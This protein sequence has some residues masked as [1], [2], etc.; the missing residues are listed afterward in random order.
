MDPQS[1]SK[2]PSA[3][4]FWLVWL[5]TLALVAGSFFSI[6]RFIPLADKATVFRQTSHGWEPLPPLAS[7]GFGIH[8][9]D[10]GVAWVQTLKGLSRLEGASWRSYTK[11]DFGT[12]HGYIPGQF[13]LDGEDV[14]CATYEGMLHF[15]GKRWRRYPRNVTTA[16]ATSI[17]AARGQV[18]VIDR[19]GNLSHFDGSAWA[20]RKVDLPG[21][22]WNVWSAR[23]PKLAV[24]GNGALWLAYQGLW[25]YDGVSWTRI[26]SASSE[27]ELLGATPPGSYLDGGKR[28]VTGGGVWVF[29]GG[30]VVG[31]DVDGAPAVRYKL[32]DLGL[33]DSARVYGIAGQAP[34]FAVTSSQGL[35][36]FDGNQWHRERLTRLG[37]SIAS[38]IAVA[39]DGSVW[40]IGSPTPS[41]TSFVFLGACLASLILPV[42]AIVYPIWW[43]KRKAR[44]QRQITQEAVLHATGTL[45]EDL[46]GPEPSGWKTAGGVVA[47]LVLGFGSYRMV[48]HYWPAAPLWVLPALFLAAHVVTTV[49]GSLKKRKPQPSDPIGPGGPPRY[50]WAKSHTAI[51][52]GLAVIVLLYGGSIAR[53]YHI[54]WLATAPGI[55]F[56]FGGQFLFRAYEMFRGH[57]VEREIKACR[58]RKALEM[59]DGPLGWP[60]TGLWKLVRA[61]VLFFSGRALEAEPIYERWWKPRKSRPVR[62]WRLNSSAGS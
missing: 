38:S 62:R 3:R 15:D 60:S 52:G 46:Q 51:L 17:A 18:W 9:S 20:V 43:R 8:I 55:A 22:P 48:K 36:W 49:T 10:S 13:T 39:P 14:W 5:T 53:H 58:Y 59:L 16:L 7:A 61:D 47:F 23:R 41:A 30:E 25:R 21:V 42:V 24:T 35:V 50:D 29:E 57:R 40:G 34:V 6:W 28:V 1:K 33:T 4:V 27:A 44:Y 31:Y 56:L 32:H 11:S 19:E 2:P 45:P 37:I 26:P 54:P 12:E